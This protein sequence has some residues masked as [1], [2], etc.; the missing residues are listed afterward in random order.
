FMPFIVVIP[1]RY[2]S[3]RL[4]GKPLLEI[5]GK[6]MLQHVVERARRSQAS[7]VY[8]ATDDQRIR[9]SCEKFG[10]SALMT[11]ADHQSGTDRIEEVARILGLDD[12]AI[13]VNVQG[14]EPLMPPSVIN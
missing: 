14:D 3:T 9:A 8:V 6:P 13:V 12:D 4:P 5:A 11:S 1:A 2:N 10:T 7:A